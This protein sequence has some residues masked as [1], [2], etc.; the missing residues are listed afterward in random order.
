MRGRVRTTLLL[1]AVLAPVAAGA[2][3]IDREQMRYR[4]A[5]A[6]CR[7]AYR[8][9]LTRRGC[10]GECATRAETRRDR[11]LAATER[12]YVEALRR[13]LRPLNR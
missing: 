10:V 9:A 8:V 1:L 6:D 4:L 7:E 11:C 3:S 13:Q 5:Q 12:R 2:Q